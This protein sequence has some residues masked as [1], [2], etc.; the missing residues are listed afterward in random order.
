MW[1]TG[2]SISKNLFLVHDLID[3]AERQ[4]LPVALLSLDQEKAFDRVDW[5]FLLRIL[6]KLNFGAGFR[7]WIKRFYTDVES[8]VV[9]NGWT[10]SFF[11]PSLGVRQGCPLSPLLYVLCIEILVVSIR[12]APDVTGVHLPNSLEQFKCLG[13]ADDT[14]IAATTDGSIEEV[15]RST[16]SLNGH[17]VRDLIVASLR[18]CGLGPGKTVRTICLAF[19]G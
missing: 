18:A 17:L 16:I 13:Y 5:D 1:C 11:H 15:L 8:A 4:D 3:Y 9:I 7:A 12:N 6:E 14:T 10:S 2:C 19:S